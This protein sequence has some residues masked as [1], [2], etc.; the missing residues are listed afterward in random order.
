[1]CPT[2]SPVD[3]LAFR[4]AAASYLKPVF[5]R[6]GHAL[7]ILA[8]IGALGGHW[9]VL[10]TVAW[11]N[12]LA[13]HLRTSSLEVALAK[14][15]DGKNPCGLCKDITAG[16]QAEKKTEFPGCAK[17]LEFIADRT[18]FVF[19]PP[20]DFHLVPEKAVLAC[21]LGHEPPVPPPRR[22]AS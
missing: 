6:L 2:F 1:M 5:K 17:K 9:A 3:I 18:V 7:L 10:Q 8:L 13:T 4:E 14:T 20:T 22:F 12:M 19:S 16:R 21:L 15:F 11:T